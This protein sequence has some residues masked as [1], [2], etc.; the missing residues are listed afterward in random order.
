MKEKFLFEEKQFLPREDVTVFVG[1]KKLTSD[2]SRAIRLK[3][4]REKAKEFLINECK[5]S[6]D[7]F[8]EVDWDLLD[9][10]LGE[11]QMAIRYGYPS[12]TQVF[13]ALDS[14]FPTT[15]GS[16][17]SKLGVLTAGA[18]KWQLISDVVQARTEPSCCWNQWTNCKTGWTKTTKQKE[19]WRTEYPST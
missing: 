12:S 9:A 14:R 6:S 3:A 16:K 2:L 13:V 19:S 5:L 7:K 4:S 17:G 18:Q 11:K 1:G 10:T 15:E 8:D